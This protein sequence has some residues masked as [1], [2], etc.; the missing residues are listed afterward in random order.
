MTKLPT[1][2]LTIPKRVHFEDSTKKK[3][4]SGH[5]S[6][7]LPKSPYPEAAKLH[8]ETPV[9]QS[10]AKAKNQKEEP[11]V[12]NFANLTISEPQEAIGAVP[13]ESQ[14]PLD[15]PPA[16][17]EMSFQPGSHQSSI[18]RPGAAMAS[19]AY[20][21]ATPPKPGAVSYQ[22]QMPDTTNG[23]EVHWYTPRHDGTTPYG[24]GFG[25]Q[26]VSQ[27]PFQ[28]CQPVAAPFPGQSPIAMPFQQVCAP[29]QP[30]MIQHP[31]AQSMMM[32]PL[33]PS[34]MYHA[35]MQPALPQPSQ[36]LFIQNGLQQQQGMMMLGSGAANM[37]MGAT[38]PDP[39]FGVG[40][41]ASEV[42]MMN[43]QYAAYSNVDE[44]QEFQPADPDPTRMYRVRDFDGSW[45]MLSRKTIDRGA[46]RWYVTDGGVFYAVR[47]VG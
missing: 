41:T 9:Q 27:H 36:P 19:P 40:Y 45:A 5:L 12:A 26:M 22:P 6:S 3:N 15:P 4:P 21:N 38:L 29:L 30:T 13:L 47:L 11:P 10:Q 37:P 8:K 31:I 33:A 14:H 2:S 20:E 24:P 25:P 16:Y 34:A 44:P 7:R 1:P 18:R 17:H 28:S 39:A 23:P 32:Q 35:G 42:A 46:F 43:N